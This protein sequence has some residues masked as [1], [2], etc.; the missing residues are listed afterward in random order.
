MSEERCPKCG[1][2]TL[3][4]GYGLAGGGIGSYTYC[5]TESCDYFDKTQDPGIGGDPNEQLC[6]HMK[7]PK[8]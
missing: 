3:G 4:F 8:P 1:N 2:E 6:P 5:T 7:E